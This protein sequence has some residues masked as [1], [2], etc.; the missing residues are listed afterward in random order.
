MN[1]EECESRGYREYVEGHR[2]K[3]GTW[4]NGFCRRKRG[5]A[6]PDPQ[7]KS[8]YDTPEERKRIREEIKEERK[9]D[10]ELSRGHTNPM[11][12]WADVETE[13]ERSYK[14]YKR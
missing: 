11:N 12:G 9:L 14:K 5:S 6:W 7:I 4:V 2:K 13:R 1:R 10:A 8:S 3:D